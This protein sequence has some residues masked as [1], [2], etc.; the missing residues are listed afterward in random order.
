[1]CLDYQ[2]TE[3]LVTGNPMKLSR[4]SFISFHADPN[5]ISLLLHPL[6]PVATQWFILKVSARSLLRVSVWL[7]HQSLR[8]SA[9]FLDT[10]CF[11]FSLPTQP[12][13]PITMLRRSQ[14]PILVLSCR[15]L[16]E[17]LLQYFEET[18]RRNSIEIYTQFNSDTQLSRVFVIA[19]GDLR[20]VAF[21][22]FGIHH[23]ELSL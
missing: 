17:C 13:V 6:F 11:P 23:N 18:H 21:F 8:S 7:V 5:K 9:V 14:L 2:H 22:A 15:R 4:N 1:M 10:F 20:Q 12:T 16:P 3:K 19:S